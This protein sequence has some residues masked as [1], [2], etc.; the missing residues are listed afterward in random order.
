M[1]SRRRADIDM[2]KGFA[3][4][5]VVFGHLVA[6]ADPAG[7]VWYEPLRRAVYAFHMPF[8][9]YLSGMVAV[10]SGSLLVPQADWLKLVQARAE[11]LLIPFFG[12]GLTIVFCKLFAKNFMFVDNQ[13]AGFWSGVNALFWR[14][15]NSPAICIW[16]LFVL[17]IISVFTPLI[18]QGRPARLPA[19]FIMTLLLYV[20]PAPAY[21]YLDHVSHYAVFFVFGAWAATNERRWTAFM[22]RAWQPLLFLFAVLLASIAFFGAEWPPFLTLLPVG[23][24]SMPALHGL[25]R[26]FGPKSAPVFLFLGRYSFMIYLF[27]TLFIGLAKGVL[28]HFCS[29]DAPH[30]LPFAIALMAAGTF[31]PVALKHYAFQRNGILQKFTN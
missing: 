18:L 2:A 6:R 16:Y 9:L 4:L 26:N 22:D 21:I 11:R 23:L 12:L 24:L 8:F 1:I 17:F 30:F 3:I 10:F 29:W 19:I 5:F 13:P 15:S 25:V 20:A 27:N 14:T 31:G 28:L 7:V